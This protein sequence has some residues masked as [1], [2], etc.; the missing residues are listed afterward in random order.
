MSHVLWSHN[1]LR[2]RQCSSLNPSSYTQIPFHFTL[3]HHD[4]YR[5][6]TQATIS[7]RQEEHHVSWGKS[8]SRRG[9]KVKLTWPLVPAVSR[10]TTSDKSTAAN[11]SEPITSAWRVSEDPEHA[12]PCPSTASFRLA[13]STVS[14]V[15]SS[16][17]CRLGTCWLWCHLSPDRREVEVT[18]S[19]P[20]HAAFPSFLSLT[21]TR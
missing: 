12:S 8:Y 6:A 10:R 19:R 2:K 3:P 20:H 9:M 16:Q 21:V 15:E 17:F 11:Q 14:T 13:A 1:H 7:H 18:A 4:K 5:P